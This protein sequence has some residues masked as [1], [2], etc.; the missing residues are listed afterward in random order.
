MAAVGKG[1]GEERDLGRITA[2][3]EAPHELSGEAAGLA[4]VDAHICDARHAQH[5]GGERH[6]WHICL[7]QHAD[8]LAHQGVVL[9][10]QANALRLAA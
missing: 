1:A 10:Y 3:K 4:I 6:H 7:V 8:R 9:C 5:V 2:A